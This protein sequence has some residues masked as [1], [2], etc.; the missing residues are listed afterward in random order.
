MNNISK[1]ILFIT[2]AV[3][4]AACGKPD[5]KSQLAK[6]QKQ[7]DELNIK[8]KKLENEL[9]INNAT[10]QK[11]LDVNVMEA[12]QDV[13]SHFIELQG[14]LDGKDNIAVSAQMPGSITAVY[15]KEGD[16]V[17]KGQVLAQLD[18]N[19]MS[20][21]LA[22]AKQQL[23]FATNI[24]NKQKALWEQQIGSEVQ[25]LSAKNNMESAAKGVSTLQNQLN[26]SRIVS[27]IN[28]R[29]E[30]VNLK[31]GQMASPGL[32]AVRVVNFASAKTLVDI[33]ES[34]S[35]KVKPGSEVSVF[36]PDFNKEIKSKLRFTS[37]F[38]NPTNRTF[39]AEIP[40]PPS[41]VEYRANM[42]ATVKIKDYTNPKA[43]IIPISLIKEINGAKHLFIAKEENGKTVARMQTITTGDT[44]NGNIEIVSGISAGD[45]I[46]T[47]GAANLV[48]GQLINVLK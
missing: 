17:R 41:N 6:L 35:A 12:K 46:I 7:R 23:D 38:I 27:P 10:S 9:N 13:F 5:K 22:S 43:F 32:P 16:A 4:M 20:Q 42:M 37:K 44:Y 47:A 2:L 26:L 40:L 28:G 39:Q 25:Y 15:V 8:I 19:V 11:L 30:E 21:Q 45:K 24:Y 36:F 3:F 1:S 34:Y 29:V 18:N 33:P 31:V 14:K 48:D